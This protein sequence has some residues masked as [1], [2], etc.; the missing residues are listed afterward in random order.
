MNDKCNEKISSHFLRQCFVNHNNFAV[1]SIVEILCWCRSLKIIVPTVVPT[2]PTIFFSRCII[3]SWKI[4][5]IVPDLEM[6]SHDQIYL[7]H[8]TVICLWC[9]LPCPLYSA[10]CFDCS[11]SVSSPV[12]PVGSNPVPQL[13]QHWPERRLHSVYFSL[14]FSRSICGRLVDFRFRAE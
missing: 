4:T 5:E 9:Q 8:S 11:N 3:G 10:V 6:F 1:V 12:E 2:S 13:V 7:Y 14:H